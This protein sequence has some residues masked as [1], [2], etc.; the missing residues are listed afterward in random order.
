M[1]ARRGAL[2]GDFAAVRLHKAPS[3]CEP[4]A[5]PLPAIGLRRIGLDEFVEYLR[6]RLRWN[7]WPVVGYPQRDLPRANQRID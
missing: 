5:G 3:D 1:A 6:Q 4:E 7:A 2:G